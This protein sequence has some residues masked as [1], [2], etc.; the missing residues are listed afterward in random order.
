M[1]CRQ[2]PLR[3]AEAPDGTSAVVYREV[4]ETSWAV[5]VPVKERILPTAFPL[6]SEKK[7]LLVYSAVLFYK[8][9][10]TMLFQ[11]LINILGATAK[12]P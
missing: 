1:Y 12:Y 2:L 3:K 7:K 6:S 5:P 4:H 8:R 9:Q 10:D 11:K